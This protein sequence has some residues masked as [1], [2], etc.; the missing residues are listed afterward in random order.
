MPFVNEYI[1]Q[2]D[3]I[4][5]EIEAINLKYVVGGTRARDW[6]ID[7]ERNIYIRNVANG[8]ED[9]F[10]ESTWTLF[11]KDQLIEFGLSNISHQVNAEGVKI[12]HKKLRYVSLPE[13]LQAQKDAVI[14]VI[15]EALTAYKDG[16]VFATAAD[17]AVALE[18]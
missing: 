8:R 15:T 13:P 12:G 2:D 14:A 5:Y 17:Y 18:V 9:F 3:L 16:G 6:T 1:P 10:H 4:K 7:R 11:Y